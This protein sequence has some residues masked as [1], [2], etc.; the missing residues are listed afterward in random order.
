MRHEAVGPG[1]H[2]WRAR[3]NDNASRP[4]RA[5]RQDDPDAKTLQNNETAKPNRCHRLTVPP[6]PERAQPGKVQGDHYRIMA[7]AGLRRAPGKQPRRV[8]MCEEQF[9]H[10]LER[11]KPKND[12]RR[13]HVARR[14]DAQ[15]AVNPGPRDVSK[16]RNGTLSARTRSNTNKTVGPDIFP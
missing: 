2:Q 10:A 12:D 1:C 8:A 5:K 15:L 3:Q 7:G 16:D 4:A 11:D 14:S 13:N 9:A 6:Y